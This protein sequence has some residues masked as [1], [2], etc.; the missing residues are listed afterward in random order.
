LQVSRKRWKKEDSR[1]QKTEFH[2]RSLSVSNG[3][4]VHL[5]KKHG[6]GR[7]NSKKSLQGENNV[8]DAELS[9]ENPRALKKKGKGR[10]G[11]ENESA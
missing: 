5:G 9:G 2:R 10:G 11:G 1:K 4:R 6:A 8:Q 3:G 7:K